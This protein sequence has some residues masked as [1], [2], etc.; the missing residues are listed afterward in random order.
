MPLQPGARLAIFVPPPKTLSD[1]LIF[2]TVTF[3]QL[4]TTPLMVCGSPTTTGPVQFLVTLMH[5]VRMFEHVALH[6]LT[7]FEP[8]RSV[9]L[10]VMTSVLGEQGLAGT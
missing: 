9:P 1:K 8:S 4:E 5:E 6:V 3:P 2:V 10:T 7:T